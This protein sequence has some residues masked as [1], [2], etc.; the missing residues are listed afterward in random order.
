MFLRAASARKAGQ[1][2]DLG[3]VLI[4]MCKVIRNLATA[5]L[6]VVFFY[7][8]TSKAMYFDEFSDAIEAWSIIPIAT[9]PAVILLVS[10]CDLVAAIWLISKW[11]DSRPRI[12][13]ISLLVIY[14]S[15][16]FIEFYASGDVSCGCFG[17]SIN[18]NTN[19]WFL[20]A[21]NIILAMLCLLH[22]SMYRKFGRS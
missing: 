8:G 20:L 1:N 13:I 4:V 9:R 3:T 10:L 16:V 21:R 11:N 17:Q 7:A 19:T 14:T 6:V 22:P 5:V 12:F 2:K 18:K 15:A